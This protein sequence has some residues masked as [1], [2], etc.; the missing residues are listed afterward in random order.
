ML[1]GRFAGELLLFLAH[2]VG[3]APEH[4]AALDLGEV[5]DVSVDAAE[6]LAVNAVCVE[7]G[8]QEAS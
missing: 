7:E 2:V 4:G 8:V 6:D 1:R 5:D 3:H